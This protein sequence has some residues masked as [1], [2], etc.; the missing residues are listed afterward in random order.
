M[1]PRIIWLDDD[2]HASTF[3]P[4]V[5][6]F[7]KRFEIIECENIDDF[8]KNI[9]TY[10][11]DAA[12]LDVLNAD[13]KVTDIINSIFLIGNNKMWFVFSGKPQVTKNDGHDIMSILKSP[14][15]T[16][17]YSP[18]LIYEK[19][20]DE[21]DL[22]RDIE[23]AVKN[24]RTWQ[25]ENEYENVLNI[26]DNIAEDKDCRSHL[27]EILCAA[28]GVNPIDTHLY[29]NRIRV[30]LEWM[31]RAANEKGILHDKCIDVHKR[32]NLTEASLFMAGKDATLAGVRC[33]TTI[34]PYIIA[35]NVKNIL[36]ITGGASHTTKVEDKDIVNLTSYWQEI[37]TPYLLFSLTFMLCDI[38][39]WF[40]RYSQKHPDV[41][42]NQS[43]WED[44]TTTKDEIVS[45]IT[46]VDVKKYEGLEGTVEMDAN[47][48][49]HVGDC[50]LKYP[51]SVGTRMKLIVVE[52]NK[53]WRTKTTYPGFIAK[54]Q[55]LK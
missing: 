7:K 20:S 50:Y 42:A 10:E 51:I 22:M 32:V 6:R 18:K 28:S 24:Q 4:T 25:V 5:N 9:K 1:R 54:Y 31:F 40:D 30:I 33:K 41:K 37:D 11:W 17:S 47:D 44:I 8:R 46:N 14:D 23:K 26:V 27:L 43:L 13:E 21:D 45:P 34:F 39:V 3:V 53:D 2:I 15:Y 29:Y 48:N 38:L 19:S 49:L 12:I 35:Q 52:A 16:R 55:L 36:N